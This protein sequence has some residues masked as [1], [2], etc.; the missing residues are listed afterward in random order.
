[1]INTHSRI[2]AEPK[3]NLGVTSPMFG[4]FLKMEDPQS[5]LV[6][7]LKCSNFE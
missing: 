7:I 4:G 3:V 2:K 6:S 1:M 5:P